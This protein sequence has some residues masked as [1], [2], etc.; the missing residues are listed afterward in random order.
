MLKLQRWASQQGV[1]VCWRG[2]IAK[3][4]NKW[5]TSLSISA[6][7]QYSI[8]TE[9]PEVFKLTNGLSGTFTVE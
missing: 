6:V 8:K 4:P 2:G 5:F 1:S 9:N 7:R 3:A